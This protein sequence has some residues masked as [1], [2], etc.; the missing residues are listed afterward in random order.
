MEKVL[1]RYNSW[2]DGEE[3]P[4][5]L[6]NRISLTNLLINQI[7]NNLVVFITGLRRVGKTSIFKLLIY[8]LINELNIDA[9]SIL[10][11]S[12]DDYLLRKPSI[13]DIVEE[14][15]KINKLKFSDKL[16]LFL[17]EITYKNEFELQL[18]NLNDSHNVKIF[19]SSSSASLLKKGKPYLTGR[20][21]TFEVL[22][23]DFQE[24]LQFKD[25]TIRN[26]DK[27]LIDNYFNDFLMSGGIPEYVI[28]NDPAYLSTLIDDVIYKDISAIFN[29]KNPEILKD[30]FLLLMERSGKLVSLNK[31]AKILSISPDTSR[32]YFEY[33]S[34][35]FLIYPLKRCGRT[36][37]II[38]SQKKVYAPDIGIRNHMTGFRDKG[39][40]FEN[41][42]YLKIKHLSPCYYFKNSIELDFAIK[43][44][45]LVEAKFHDEP[46][47]NKQ[48]NLFNSSNFKFKKTI[49]NSVQL[50]ELVCETNLFYGNK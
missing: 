21:I 3:R 35:V 15:R 8:K 23:L 2:W 1:S 33:F 42:V 46:L 32:R 40:L 20:N 45:F 16:Y 49:R 34:D 6:V 31:I 37:E 19:A 41:Y 14:F 24:Y 4:L 17:D 11:V 43:N 38:L 12:L 44:D 13:I 27:H 47:S 29:I 25:I 50:N 18:K 30:Y 22:P 5:T 48:Q 9:R 28:N 36:N 39:S 7:T 10:Y 26:Q